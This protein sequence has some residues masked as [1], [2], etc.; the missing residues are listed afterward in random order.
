MKIK[1]ILNLIKKDDITTVRIVKRFWFFTKVI[2]EGS[3]SGIDDFRNKAISTGELNIEYIHNNEQ[4]SNDLY[5]FRVKEFNI[6]Y[7][8]NCIEIT[9][10]S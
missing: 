4:F 8:M 10:M 3:L 5:N 7:I 2:Y 1:D 6:N 9:I